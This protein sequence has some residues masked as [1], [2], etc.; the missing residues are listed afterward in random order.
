MDRQGYYLEL[1]RYRKKYFLIPAL[2][3]AVV[4]TIIIFRLPR[5]YESK[6]TILIEE[7]QIPPEF[8]RSTVTGFAEQHIQM[9]NQQ[10]LSRS[11]LQEIIDKFNLYPEM[12]KTSTREEIIEEMRKDIAFRT[13]SAQV[14]D[15]KKGPSETV[16]IAFNVIYQ[17]KDPTTVQNVA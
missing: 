13:I 10:I 3:V 12:Q 11:R 15:K 6:A 8:V 17:G 2:L 4:A 1:W 7:Q 9:L 5:I 16:T 14:R